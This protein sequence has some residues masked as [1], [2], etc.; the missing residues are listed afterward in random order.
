MSGL[1]FPSLFLVGCVDC[2]GGEGILDGRH[3]LKRVKVGVIK[4]LEEVEV[5]PL[6]RGHRK[7]VVLKGN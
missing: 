2:G 3:R 1:V 5:V 6:S 4:V 7:V